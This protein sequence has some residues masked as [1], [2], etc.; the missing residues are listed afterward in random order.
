MELTGKLESCGFAVECVRSSK[1]ADLFEGE[2][3][4][5]WYK[6]KQGI[7]EVLFLHERQDFDGLEVIDEPTI[8][9]RHTYTF[10]GTPRTST[11]MEGA[12]LITFVRHKN[13]MFEVMNNEALAHR[14]GRAFPAK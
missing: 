5:A 11:R 9:G 7:F 1:Q 4:A 13:L 10:R 8:G 14:L 12:S 6:T 2:K 3:G